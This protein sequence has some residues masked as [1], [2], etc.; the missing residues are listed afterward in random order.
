MGVINDNGWNNLCGRGGKAI[1]RYPPRQNMP[2]G[3]KLTFPKGS[4]AY[5]WR[6]KCYLTCTLQAYTHGEC[7]SRLL[8]L[9]R[10]RV[11]LWV[12]QRQRNGATFSEELGQRLR[13]LAWCEKTLVQD[14]IIF[15]E[16]EAKLFRDTH[17]GRICHLEVSLPFLKDL[18]PT[19]GG[20]SVI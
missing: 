16:E 17:P 6:G 11:C 19:G 4:N 15:V 20:G 14:G 18:T 5:R 1:Q 7:Q 10:E 12:C 2:L 13:S 9:N 3:S 8:Y